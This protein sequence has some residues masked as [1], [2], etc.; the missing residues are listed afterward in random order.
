MLP[1]EVQVVLRMIRVAF[2]EQMPRRIV[3]FSAGLR[4][5]EIPYPNSFRRIKDS[6]G[7]S[8]FFH[9]VSLMWVDVLPRGIAFNALTAGR[10]DA[11]RQCG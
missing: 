6:L 9:G 4:M 2:S 1:E 5:T 3:Q 7:N 11:L 8:T 10:C